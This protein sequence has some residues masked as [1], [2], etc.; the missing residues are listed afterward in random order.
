MEVIFIAYKEI[1][2]NKYYGKV[3]N[4]KDLKYIENISNIQ[5]GKKYFAIGE[6]NND[7]FVVNE[8]YEYFET[9]GTII[10]LKPLKDKRNIA[11]IKTEDGKTLK[12]NVNSIYTELNELHIF[13]GYYKTKNNIITTFAKKLTTIKVEIKE[14]LKSLNSNYK[15]YIKAEI[16]DIDTIGAKKEKIYLIGNFTLIYKNDTIN[17]FGYKDGNKFYVLSYEKDLNSDMKML[18][19][20]LKNTLKGIIAP[21]L[22]TKI[23]NKYKEE[24]LNVLENNKEK[25][26]E[27]FKKL[28]DEVY[29]KIVLRIN[30]SKY[31]QEFFYF[32]EKKGISVDVAEY[33]YK[34]YGASSIEKLKE[35]P[36]LITEAK[37]NLFEDAD[38][39]GKELKWENNNEKR[40]IASIRY[41]LYEDS[42]SKG[43]MFMYKDDLLNELNPFLTQFGVYENSF[44]DSS[45]INK[46]LNILIKNEIIKIEDDKVYFVY[47]YVYEKESAKMI[48]NLLNDFKKPF[49]TESKID[50]CIEDFCSKYVSLETKQKIAIKKAILNNISILTGGPGTGK[51][52][53]VNAIV[54]TIININ[55]MARIRLCAPTGRASKRITEVTNYPATTIH[56]LLNL[57][58]YETISKGDDIPK[59]MQNLDYLIIDE[60][61][62]IDAKLFYEILLCLD[63]QTRLII[64]GDVNQLPS[65]G[66][67]Q[68]L[69]DL[70]KSELIE[71]TELT[72]IFRQAG[73]SNI[74]QIAH[75]MIKKETINILDYKIKEIKDVLNKDVSFIECFSLDNT[76]EN[77]YK[78]LD[79]LISNE[80]NFNQVQLL[81]PMNKG[82][83]GTNIIN[84]EIQKLYNNTTNEKE[85]YQ[86][87]SLLEIH[88]KDKVIQTVNNYDINV[89][90]GS[91]GY[92]KNITRLEDDITHKMKDDE[93]I[94]EFDE[95]DVVYSQKDLM[96][97]KLAYDIT[98]H[99]SQGSEFPIV[100]IPIDLIQKNML[101]LNLIYTAITRSKEKLILIGNKE[102]FYESLK[103][104]EKDR[105]TNFINFLKFFS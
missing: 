24:T 30:A 73:E 79:V 100:I 38:I 7:S 36:Y 63:E 60:F 41:L 102:A 49:C 1:N 22:V 105:N 16:I 44:V 71:T 45:I 13:K 67:G 20:Y 88:N 19:T 35:N 17:A 42:N 31:I 80:K 99:K 8:Y 94:I 86:I 85:K 32:C 89:M 48:L 55:P 9:I 28:T 21:A 12:A 25:L 69:K 10:D 3:L 50:F 29:S 34:Q 4:N 64:I 39:I 18:N 58:P 75:K 40:V 59:N 104:I 47:N 83:I 53:T 101:T 81:S 15:N 70:I 62:M 27:D 68:V 51:T 5:V 61:S 26:F 33:I 57:N 6:A 43:N 76:I 52:L 46:C 66:A 78:V 74:V 87:G 91:I 2:K 82:D 14:N 98:I 96:E 54:K 93:I 77:T 72:E 97:I 84:N 90:N 56:K 103:N 95:V 11:Q 92:V 65:V 23:L 37:P